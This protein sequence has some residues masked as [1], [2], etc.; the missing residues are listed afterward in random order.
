MVDMSD[1]L[2]NLTGNNCKRDNNYNTGDRDD[3]K[4]CMDL[5]AGLEWDLYT[6]PL[7][8]ELDETM[9]KYIDQLLNMEIGDFPLI[10]EDDCGFNYIPI[11]RA[12]SGVTMDT[13]VMEGTPVST[14]GTLVFK[15]KEPGYM[16]ITESFTDSTRKLQDTT[17]DNLVDF[18]KR[19]VKVFQQDW[20]IN[21][22]FNSTFNPWAEYLRHPYVANRINN[23][24]L[25]RCN[26]RMKV[27]VN[28]NGF[29]YGRLLV[30]YHPLSGYDDLSTHS[31]LIAEDVVQTSQLPHIFCNPTT[32]AGGEMNIPFFW[33]Q[34][35]FDVPGSN[36]GGIA[37]VPDAGRVYLRS[38]NPLRI[39]GSGTVNSVTI[40][41]FVWAEDMELA[42]PT[43]TNLNT[44]PP[45]SGTEVAEANTKGMVSGP[46]TVVSKMAGI[47]ASYPPL[48]PF[49][50]ATQ[51]VAG[52]VAAAAKIMGYSRPPVTANPD[53]FRPTPISQLA[54]TTTPDTALKMTV[55]DL[56]E[57][58]IDPRIS[59]VGAHDP[60]IIRD[61]AKRES[62]LTTFEWA[63]SRAPTNLL[64]NARV[65]PVLWRESAGGGIHL[66]ACA[67][68][69][70][71]FKYWTGT[72]KFRFQI[73]SS[74]FHRG[75]LEIRYDPAFNPADAAT[76][77]D[78]NLNHIHVVDI[79]EEQDFT[80]S[81]ANAQPYSLL[82]HLVPGPNS[83]TEGFS[84]TSYVGAFNGLCNGVI[85]VKV[86]NEL[87]SSASTAADISVNVFVSAGDDFEV[88][89]PTDEF[90]RY[91]FFPQ[92]GTEQVPD[93]MNTVEPSAPQQALTST[94][95]GGLSY[96]ADLNKVFAGESIVSF[97]PML[98]RYNFWRRERV[99]MEGLSDQVKILRRR[100]AYPFLRRGTTATAVDDSAT[101]PY[102]YCNTVMLHWIT[103]CFA[104]YRGS[105][106]YKYI[107]T[108]SAECAGGG[109]CC[110]H[111]GSRVYVERHDPPDT[112]GFPAY[113]QF[114]NS[115]LPNLVTPSEVSRTAMLGGG[116]FVPSGAR[117]S[118]FA[119][120]LIN[121]AVEFEVP[122]QTQFRFVPGKPSNYTTDDARFLNRYH[123]TYEGHTTPEQEVDIHTASG[124]DFQVYFWTGL[125]RVYYEVAPPQAAEPGGIVEEAS[126]QLNPLLETVKQTPAVAV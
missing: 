54:T 80:I 29:S 76:I 16:S 14:Q 112:A 31:A 93:S 85:S 3:R 46:A 40:T 12:Q 81:I 44:L 103:N 91:T 126:Q 57:L 78:F 1:G 59:G 26:L 22:N 24:K 104:G 72:I 113:L 82:K 99:S 86:L 51:K 58:T 71:P 79:A 94:M 34:N 52:S 64:W 98:K 125:P 21:T 70:L 27:V 92:S 89:V 33:H 97:R 5:Q 122:Y 61:I 101:G 11:F 117:G 49:A 56:Q 2:N 19:P 32:S 53:P 73:V 65:N 48:A 108:E 37:G 8:V 124:E 102:N 50:L 25:L 69:A 4:N 90:Q 18:Y 38:L 10:E 75:R 60:L 74:A 15:D 68:A 106:R 41:I 35:Y 114:E 95:N 105:I 42:Q 6:K 62:Y 39:I 111:I 9:F 66:P 36:W 87:I 88:F 100:S 116:D 63:Q 121:P 84:T 17:N 23:Y 55:D 119:T 96:S 20:G 118:V 67:V 110:D 109:G 77:N 115:Y 30:A 123:L 120:D 107:F 13:T 7:S 83:P 43:G 47:A 45:Q 28:G